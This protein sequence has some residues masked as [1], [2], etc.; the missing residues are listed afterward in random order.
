MCTFE[1]LGLREDILKAITELGYETPMPVQKEVIPYLLEGDHDVV[2]LA[3]T[4]TGKT[5]TFGLPILQKID[6]SSKST[7]ALILSPTR[8]LCVQIAEDLKDYSK[9]IEGVRIIPVYGGAS[10]RN[11]IDALKKECQIIVA[12]PGRLLD[13]LSRGC[14]D[15]SNVSNIVMDEADEMLNMGFQEDIDPILEAVP[16]N[17]NTLLFSATMPEEIEKIAKTYMRDPKEIVIGN[18]NESTST[19]RHIYY[20]VKAQDKYQTLKRIVDFYPRIYGIIFC[21]TKVETQ[22]IADAL[23][24]DGYSVDALHGDLS[25]PQ[26]DYV[27]RR[28][29]LHGIQLLVATDVAARGLD[30]DDLTHIINYTLPD[31]T[32]AY[33]HRSGRTGRAGK[34]GIS[35]AII[36]MKEMHK[37]KQIERITGKTFEVGKIPTGKEICTKQIFNLMDRIENVDV[38]EDEIADLLPPV[39][40]KL[41]WLTKEEIIKRL[42]SM[43]FNRIIEYYQTNEDFEALEAQKSKKE[44]GIVEVKREEGYTKVFINLGKMDGLTPKALLGLINDCVGEKVDIGRIDLF[45]RY[46]LF[47]VK[48]EVAK[49]VLEE[50]STLRMRGRKLR[51]NEATAEQIG[52]GSKAKEEMIKAKEKREVSKPMPKDKKRRDSKKESR[53]ERKRR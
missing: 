40:R 27:M 1:S 14:V 4:G 28:F 3:Q 2:T 16:E 19:V 52:R 37:V 11:Q 30:V 8:E 6:P 12:T 23:I 42:V 20:M 17:R 53:K 35:I 18:K 15:L 48:D 22:E 47:D 29:R 32:E 25:Q 46:S 31:E 36:N 21:R 5:A 24:H 51:C 7:Q 38:N 10:I 26:R 45:T 50:M 9:Y 33:T 39:Y 44:K 43:E 13:L 49:K 34:T 41:E